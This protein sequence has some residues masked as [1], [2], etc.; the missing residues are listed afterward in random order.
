M[1]FLLALF[2]DS[3]ELIILVGLVKL[4]VWIIFI[5]LGI[6]F[7]VDVSDYLKDIAVSLRYLRKGN[8]DTKPVGKVPYIPKNM[9]F[10]NNRVYRDDNDDEDD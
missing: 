3:V 4:T 9:L 5:V 1:D 8:P 6:R 7:L 10:D 2:G